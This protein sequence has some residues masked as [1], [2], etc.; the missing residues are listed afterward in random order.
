[1]AFSCQIRQGRCVV[2]DGHLIFLGHEFLNAMC[3]HAYGR[4][5]YIHKHKM[6]AGVGNARMNE[7]VG[8]RHREIKMSRFKSYLA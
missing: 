6:G 8:H 7:M 3:G 5:G 4:T 2:L 1:M